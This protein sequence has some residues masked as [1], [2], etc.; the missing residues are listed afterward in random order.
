VLF[1]A[2]YFAKRWELLRELKE[3]VARAPLVR[4]FNVPRLEYAL[5]LLAGMALVLGFF[6]LQKDLGPALVLGT[7]FLALYAI[8]RRRIV[9]VLAGFGLLAGTVSLGYAIGMP[10]TVVQRIDMWRAP[11]DNAVRGGDQLAHSL[12]ALA[13]GGVWG[14][15]PGRGSPDVIPA[16]HTDLV[17]AAFGEEWGFLG[18][19]AVFAAYAAIVARAL[20][21]ARRAPGD[22]TMFLALGLM[23]SLVLQVLLIAGG[24]LGLLPLSGVVTPFLSFGR[25][26]MLANFA[27]VGILL[28]ISDRE[29]AA[30]AADSAFTR[31]LRWL[32]VA[33]ALAGA[34]VLAKIA[35]VQ[36]VQADTIAS[37]SA[38]GL[39][40]DGARRYQYNPRLVEAANAIA[41]GTIF[42]RRGVPLATS[43][44]DVIDAH[45]RELADLGAQVST[46][47][48]DPARRCYPFGGLTFH[49]LGDRDSG[50]NWAASNTSFQERDSDDRL[51]G[52]D[53]HAQIVTLTNADG[54]TGRVIRRSYRD[55]VPLLPSRRGA[56]HAEAVRRI[57]ERPRD[58]RMSID[59]RL[60]AR[61]AAILK[62]R[63]E[64]GHFERAAVVALDPRTGD[65]L[66][67]VS[68]PWPAARRV[69]G[70]D[71]PG[72]EDEDDAVFD[73]ARYG[74]Y[75]PGST[76]KIVTAAAA[77][78]RADGASESTFACVRLPGGGVGQRVGGRLIHDDPT[79]TVP[80]GNIDMERAL[81]VS[82]NAYFAQLG[83]RIGATALHETA[84]LFGVAAASPDTVDQLRRTLVDAAYG[85]GQVLIT[86]FKMARVAATIA[87]GGVMPA[88]RW[89]LGEAAPGATRR[90]L[91]AADARRIAQAM[92]QVVVAGTGRALA[93]LP[94]TVAGKT[95]TAEIEGRASHSWFAGY[96]PY[97]G[98]KATRTIAFAV[99]V[100]NG[101]YGARA[102]AP[103][104]AELVVAARQLAIIGEP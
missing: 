13:S 100:E 48:A 65:L 31:P 2:G 45:R 42:D 73:R 78:R 16:A 1:L 47:C 62:R 74:V 51:R 77:L 7:L 89:V 99:L 55:L 94:I 52:F 11:F 24:V 21:I 86:P 64:A 83:L 39:Q 22:Y 34:A 17:L 85:Q 49:L 27:S 59:V 26:S 70:G 6:F 79:D 19:V 44:T 12:W 9:L 40:A 35:I 75:P 33:L 88:G 46:L 54:T 5:P 69:N 32:T 41:R 28:A 81:V 71:E 43:R 67:A 76:F 98:G 61:I 68:Y 84:D 87:S 72:P 104:A 37:A 50:V 92:R 91:E 23:L 101:G 36:V 14:M 18:L 60:Q 90:V 58:V 96:A 95:G 82:C 29:D 25:S 38:L 30:Q 4:W 8:A 15:A 66:A 103:I 97:G 20:R 63:M 57:L 10:A 53:D 102:A 80:H 56:A 93:D 3:D